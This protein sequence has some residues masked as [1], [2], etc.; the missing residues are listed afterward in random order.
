MH[1]LKH[2]RTMN[3]K[4]DSAPFPSIS[5]AKLQGALPYYI[6]IIINRGDRGRGGG[7]GK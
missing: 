1:H 6:I 2:L 4:L 7:G 3:V 5:R